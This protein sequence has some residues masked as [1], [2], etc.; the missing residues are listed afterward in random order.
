[1]QLS[2]LMEYTADV[3]PHLALFLFLHLYNV[4]VDLPK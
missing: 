1:M 3:V 4:T 2:N